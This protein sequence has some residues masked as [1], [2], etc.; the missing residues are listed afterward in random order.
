LLTEPAISLSTNRR[1][2][3]NRIMRVSELHLPSTPSHPPPRRPF[4]LVHAQYGGRPGGFPCVLFLFYIM[5]TQ[6]ASGRA[7][8]FPSRQSLPNGCARSA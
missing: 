6:L 1:M 3:E 7:E 8:A 4:A 2:T 5:P